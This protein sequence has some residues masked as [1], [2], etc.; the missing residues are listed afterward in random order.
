ME[1]APPR[2]PLK[3]EAKAANGDA[4]SASKAP[5]PP[6]KRQRS[7]SPISSSSD[8]DR[9]SLS[10]SPVSTESQ[11][12]PREPI[13]CPQPY[14]RNNSMQP[15]YRHRNSPYRRSPPR[16][17]SRYSPSNFQQRKTPTVSQIELAEEN[18]RKERL[19]QLQTFTDKLKA[20]I[21]ANT[22]IYEKNPE[23]H[24]LYSKEWQ[25]FWNK[26]YKELTNEGK[27]A[28]KHDYKPE[29]IKV[30]TERIKELNDEE[31][32][33]KIR[34]YRADI[35]LP[36]EF[37]DLSD[38]DLPSFKENIDDSKLNTEDFSDLSDDELETTI[39]KEALPKEE[40]EVTV[41]SVLRLMA[42]LEDQLGGLGH[43]VNS[44]LGQAVA[45]ETSNPG[46]SDQ[47]LSVNQHVVLLDTVKEKLKGQLFAGTVE[48]HMTMGTKKTIAAVAKLFHAQE[49]KR[50]KE[51]EAAAKAAEPVVVPGVGA[52]DSVAVAQQIAATLVAQGRTDLTDEDLEQLIGAVVGMDQSEPGKQNAPA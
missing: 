32:K 3:K 23:K 43:K 8:R 16:S 47:L 1:V 17:R 26:R 15:N 10:L 38:E 44:L 13:R 22:K 21:A 42:A 4:A 34:A 48:R 28:S 2:V 49:E 14:R 50:R 45:I 41:L 25:T 20:E 30:W 9:D 36:E 7:L 39:E 6:C 12:R 5:A 29:W 18:E 27:D 31:M 24:P 19:K 37:S 52:V 51:A 35:D 40:S 33:T 46:A 11:E